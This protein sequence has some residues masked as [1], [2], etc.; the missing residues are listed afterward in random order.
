[1]VIF[2]TRTVS[3]ERTSTS[4]PGDLNI[5]GVSETLSIPGTLDEDLVILAQGVLVKN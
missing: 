5:L 3:L 1:M 4:N 2:Q